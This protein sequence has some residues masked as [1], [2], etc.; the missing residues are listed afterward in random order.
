MNEPKTLLH[1][2]LESGFDPCYY[3]E[4]LNQLYYYNSL[5]GQERYYG[6]GDIY[7]EI[8][9]YT[10]HISIMEK[11]WV[12]LMPYDFDGE[13]KLIEFYLRLN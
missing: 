1:H 4:C 2:L 9:Y 12:P 5:F 6:D 7:D 8:Y 11:G 3:L 10:E 13:V